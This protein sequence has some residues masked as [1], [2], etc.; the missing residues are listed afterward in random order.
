MSAFRLQ[1]IIEI[2]LSHKFGYKVT[3]KNSYTQV[4]GLKFTISL[5]LAENWEIINLFVDNEVAH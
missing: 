1:I 5:V 2:I 3:K 4:N